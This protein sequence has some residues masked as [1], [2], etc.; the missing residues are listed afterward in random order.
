LPPR[1]SDSDAGA[2]LRAARRQDLA[3]TDGA[4]AGAKTV[5]AGA[6]D[7]GGLERAFHGTLG[8]EILGFKKALNYNTFYGGVSTPARVDQAFGHGREH[9]LSSHQVPA[10]RAAGPTR[11]DC[12]ACG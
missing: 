3:A 12:G 4:H 6:T 1:R 11:P 10:R 9:L 5:D 7:L 2:A 8:L